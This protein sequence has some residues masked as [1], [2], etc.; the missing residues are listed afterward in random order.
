MGER[1]EGVYLLNLLFITLVPC[2]FPPS[3]SSSSYSSS[4]SSSTSFILSSEHLLSLYTKNLSL[5]KKKKADYPFS[6]TTTATHIKSIMT[7][8]HGKCHCGQTEWTT[9]IDGDAHILW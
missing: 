7:T 3:S 6:Q 2:F 8:Y 4:Y 9:K 5:E 1:M